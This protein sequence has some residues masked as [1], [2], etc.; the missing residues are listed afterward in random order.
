MLPSDFGMPV[1][2][3]SVTVSARKLSEGFKVQL[4]AVPGRA[5]LQRM[6]C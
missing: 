4:R 3:L 2:G 1:G 5:L 6:G